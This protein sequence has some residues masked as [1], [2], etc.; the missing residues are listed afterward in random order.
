MSTERGWIVAD[1]KPAREHRPRGPEPVPQGHA[2]SRRFRWR[3]TVADHDTLALV[4][5]HRVRRPVEG[6]RRLRRRVAG[7]PLGVLE[8]SPVRRYAVMSV[9]RRR[10]WWTPLGP[11]SSCEGSVGAPVLRSPASPS[12]FDRGSTRPGR[13]GAGD[14][15]GWR[16]CP[17]STI[18]RLVLQSPKPLPATARFQRTTSSNNTGEQ[19]ASPV[20]TPRCNL[21]APR[22]RLLVS[23][24]NPSGR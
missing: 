14:R 12:T 18:R 8:R 17:A 20:K 5:R 10:A 7:D 9:R 2:A 16:E 13:F 22:S 15:R 11:R 21:R 4:D 6:L 23:R 1:G 3:A 19:P 24:E